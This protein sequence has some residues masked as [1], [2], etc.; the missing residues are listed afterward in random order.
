MLV[1]AGQ[2]T[3]FP[4]ARGSIRHRSDDRGRGRMLPP[5][6]GVYPMIRRRTA[7]RC[8]ASP[9]AGVY[10]SRLDCY[11]RRTRGLPPEASIG[12]GAVAAL[13]RTGSTTRAQTYT[14]NRFQPTRAHLRRPTGVLPPHTG[15]DRMPDFVRGTWRRSSPVHG[16]RPWSMR[17]AAVMKSFFPHTRGVDPDAPSCSLE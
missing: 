13:P 4:R 7:R 3:C 16:G 14:P 12:A 10:P 5:R 1:Y 15:V 6:T 11:R 17:S 9:H 2:Q 8:Y